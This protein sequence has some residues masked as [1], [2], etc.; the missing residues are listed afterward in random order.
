MGVNMSLEQAQRLAAVISVAEIRAYIEE[1]RKDYEA[2]L[3]EKEQQAETLT[4]KK[5]VSRKGVR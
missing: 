3:A 1:T 5:R 2:F 4:P